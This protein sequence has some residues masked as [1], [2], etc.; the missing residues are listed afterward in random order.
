MFILSAPSGAGK[1]TLGRALRKTFPHIRYSVSH[2]TRPPRLGETDGVDY[3]FISRDQFEDGIRLNRWAEWARVHG[4]YYGTS[5]TYLDQTLADGHDVLLDIDVQGTR[6]LLERYP[7]SIPIFIMPPDLEVLRK[8]LETRGTDSPEVIAKR[9][10]AAEEEINQKH[11]YRHIVINDRLPE[12]AAA[13]CD[14]IRRYT[15][16]PRR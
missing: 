6:Q 4:Y 15:S 14:V 12:A 7:D 10:A 11:I 1:T 5:A 13:L 3:F 9:L 2:T 8:R 16:S